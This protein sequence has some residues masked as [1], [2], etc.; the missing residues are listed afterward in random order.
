LARKQYHFA[1]I[2]SIIFLFF[3]HKLLIFRYNGLTK[4]GGV[5]M[6]IEQDFGARVKYLRTRKGWTQ[7]DLAKRLGYT[8]RAMVSKIEKGERGIK[9]SMVPLIADAL[10]VSVSYLLFG[11]VDKEEIT[12]EDMELLKAYY[13]A[14][15][16]IQRA[17]K[18][19][20]K[21]D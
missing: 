11:Q 21:N 19:M 3:L 20:L 8:S 6:N 10:D 13:R 18:E 1:N 7:D 14:P 16:H 17:I 2:Q 15:P 12:L 5:N 4:K 9:A